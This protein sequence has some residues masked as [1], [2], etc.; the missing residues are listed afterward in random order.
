MNGAKEKGGRRLRFY[1]DR[2]CRPNQSMTNIETTEDHGRDRPGI[3]CDVLVR[4][5]FDNN[6]ASVNQPSMAI[7]VGSRVN[8]SVLSYATPLPARRSCHHPPAI[9]RVPIKKLAG[10]SR[11]QRTPSSQPGTG[12]SP[13]A[14][15]PLTNPATAGR[16]AAPLPGT[17]NGRYTPLSCMAGLADDP[18]YGRH[19]TE[20]MHILGGYE[21]FRR[22]ESNRWPVGMY[23]GS[24]AS[25]KRIGSPLCRGNLLDNDTRLD[26]SIDVLLAE[27]RLSGILNPG[28]ASLSDSTAIWILS[29][30]D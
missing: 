3:P 14:T 10:P 2:Q 19:G 7:L 21:T 23:T 26:L 24:N 15:Q 8:H 9:V 29:S 5:L 13:Q 16:H 12:G 20:G 1:A 22:Q 27:T 18:E 17:P 25:A 30:I 6:M 11:R 28:T 4:S